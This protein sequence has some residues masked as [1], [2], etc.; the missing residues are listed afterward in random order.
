MYMLGSD[1]TGNQAEHFAE[2]SLGRFVGILRRI[3]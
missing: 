3:S 1:I 2:I